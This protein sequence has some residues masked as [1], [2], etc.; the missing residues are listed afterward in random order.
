MYLNFNFL[1]WKLRLKDNIWYVPAELEANPGEIQDMETYNFSSFRLYS[2]TNM[3]LSWQPERVGDYVQ[4]QLQ[5][6][7]KAA[8]KNGVD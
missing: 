2:V 7:V 3:F 6:L 4:Y 1:F 8:Q 5:Q